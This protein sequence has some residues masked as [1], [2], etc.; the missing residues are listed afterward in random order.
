MSRAD[1]QALL[2][3]VQNTE[4][5]ARRDLSNASEEIAALQSKHLREIDDLERQI[6]RKDREKRNLEDEMKE[7]QDDLSRERETVRELKVGSNS[8]LDL[9]CQAE[10]ITENTSGTGDPIS[11]T[12]CS[13]RGVAG[14]T[15]SFTR[16]G[17]TSI[18]VDVKYESGT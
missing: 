4:R 10:S 17:R 16:R 8:N 13:A 2:M 9:A 14:S 6:S 11:H 1:V 7:R 18:F 12:Q 15:D 5:E 3:S